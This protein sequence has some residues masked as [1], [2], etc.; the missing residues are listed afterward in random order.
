MPCLVISLHGSDL[1]I[2]LPRVQC[3]DV[4]ETICGATGLTVKNATPDKG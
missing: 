3:L 4:L 1:V 2:N